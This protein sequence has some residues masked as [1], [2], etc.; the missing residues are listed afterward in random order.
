MNANGHQHSV[1][2]NGTMASRRTA[3]A[4]TNEISGNDPL[5]ELFEACRN[6]DLVRVKKMINS[7]NVNARDTAGRK[8]SPLHFAAGDF[9][10]KDFIALHFVFFYF[11][12]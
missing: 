7:A 8:S 11:V 12:S 2:Y 6:G 4:S 3:L 1:V 10:G 9:E 5:R